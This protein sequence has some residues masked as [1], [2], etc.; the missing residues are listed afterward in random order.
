[1]GGRISP[2]SYIYVEYRRILPK[3]KCGEVVAVWTRE[4][5]GQPTRFSSVSRGESLVR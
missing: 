2:T 5:G 1:M 3:V 4:Q